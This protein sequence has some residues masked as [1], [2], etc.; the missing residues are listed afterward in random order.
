MK[1]T[2]IRGD[3][4]SGEYTKTRTACRGIVIENGSILLSYMAV[5]DCWMIP[6][7]GLE[8]NETAQECCIREFAEETGCIIRVSPCELQIDEYYDDRKHVNRYYFGEITGR[9]ER[10]PTQLEEVTGMEPRWI[11]LEEA[12]GIFSKYEAW[13][14]IDEMRYWLYRREYTALTELADGHQDSVSPDASRG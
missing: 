14:G 12:F 10:R 7:G 4:Y 2:E 5:T 1:T 8:A 11:P 6:G 9:T 3:N 13:A